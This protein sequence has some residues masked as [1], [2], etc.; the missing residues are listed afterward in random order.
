[1]RKRAIT[2]AVVAVL[3]A[4]PIACASI[5]TWASSPSSVSL[6]SSPG[7]D[8]VPAADGVASPAPQN[9]PAAGGAFFSPFAMAPVKPA[10]Q[11]TERARYLSS[12]SADLTFS[13]VTSLAAVAAFAY[14]LR[15]ASR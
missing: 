6:S 15:R 1:M 4:M 14:I 2:P 11:E 5:D 10:R 7:T 8:V 13:V 9:A 3:A 12:G